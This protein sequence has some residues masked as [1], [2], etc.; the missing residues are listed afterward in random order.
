M[1]TVSIIKVSTGIGFLSHQGIVG[2]DQDDLFFVSDRGF[3][4]MLATNA[5]GDFSAA[6]ISSDIQRTFSED[7]EE[8]RKRYIKAAYLPQINSA[9]FAVSE[10]GSAVNNSLYLYNVQSK[11]WYRWPDT[12]AETLISAQDSD[13]RRIYLGT[14]RARLAQTLTESN[15]DTDFYG[16]T[17]AIENR[18]ATGLIMV[19]GRPDTVKGFKRIRLIYRA[20]GSYAVTVKV[21]IDN[22][23][24]QAIAFSSTV[25][26]TPLGSFVLGEDIL[27]GSFV[28]A[29]YSLPVDG[30]GRGIKLTIEQ[31][32]LNTDLAIQGFMI[33][34]TGGG[35][36][37]E[38]RESD[39]S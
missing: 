4:S 2:I 10:D 15:V 35:D 8:S 6:Y 30:Y 7:F 9:V 18:V 14:Y 32:D 26:G 36:S 16:E 23:S 11:Y 21:K 24:E 12:E 39:A 25:Q 1:D 38:T 22:F 20:Q 27:G 28:T 31:T 34:Y 19:D 5:Y 37:P 33:E 29:P 17:M 13:K 3:H